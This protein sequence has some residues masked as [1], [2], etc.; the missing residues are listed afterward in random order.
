MSG[1]VSSSRYEP[2]DASPEYIKDV[3]GEL[4]RRLGQPVTLVLGDG[5]IALRAESGL[6]AG[7]SV[8]VTDARPLLPRKRAVEWADALERKVNRLSRRQRTS[9]ISTRR[10]RDHQAPR[11]R[12]RSFLSMPAIMTTTSSKHLPG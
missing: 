3:E 10:S 4:S 5:I 9:S 7:E 8:A 2:S 12:A 1:P 6:F 11:R